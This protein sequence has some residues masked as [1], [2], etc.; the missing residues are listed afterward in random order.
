MALDFPASPTNGQQFTSGGTTWTWD[1]TKWVVQGASGL[2]LPLSGGTINPGP[3]AITGNETVTGTMT[4]GGATSVAGA[5]TA[6]GGIAGPLTVNGNETVTGTLGVTGALTA[7]GG[8]A[9]PLTVNGAETV[10]GALTANSLS[11]TTTSTHTGNATFG[12][13]ASFTGPVT[14][15]GGIVGVTN[16]SNAAAGQV[17]EFLGI[18]IGFVGLTN[19][20]AANAGSLALTAGDWDVWG[21]FIF[22]M[23]GT[24]AGSIVACINTVATTI[25][26]AEVLVAL[27]TNSIGGWQGPIPYQ[28]INTSGGQTVFLNVQS[29]FS[30]G[31]VSAGG[32]IFARRAR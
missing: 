23:S 22:S 28:R 21:D 25:G 10:T 17:G 19:N 2:Y 9:G 7:S 18:S 20:V 13:T 32:H 5:L 16:A 29:G 26:G 24:V 4:I 3:L 11:V 27:T 30:S 8:I 12:G 15:S 31:S 6:S 1:G 14:P